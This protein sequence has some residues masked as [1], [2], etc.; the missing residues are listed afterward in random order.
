MKIPFDIKFRP[1]IESGEYKVET[2]DGRPVRIICWDRKYYGCPICGLAYE[3]ATDCEK[4]VNAYENGV[5]ARVT[6][7]SENDDL[8]L[9]TPDPELTEFEKKLSDVVGYAISSS[10]AEPKK[11]T[12]E[13]VK[14]YAAELLAIAKKEI[15]DGWSNGLYD[16]QDQSGKA[17]SDGYK[18]GLEEGKSEALKGIEQDPESSYAFKRGVEYGKEE[19]LKNLP[20]WKTLKDPD[21]VSR[22]VVYVGTNMIGEKTLYVRNK[23]ISVNKLK[24]LPGFKEDEK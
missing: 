20:R 19:A 4:Y 21:D 15:M 6:G 17:Y 2:R 8:F 1:Q 16:T 23:C 14:E 24:I 10:V 5:S 11:P 9:I 12:S 3:K 22:T 13:F 7:T 18:L